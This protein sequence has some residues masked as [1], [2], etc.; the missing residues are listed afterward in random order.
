MRR[1]CLLLAALLPVVWA[2]APAQTDAAI[3]Q[4]MIA[5]S[6]AAYPGNCPCPYNSMRN[7]RA[8]GGR[9]AYNRPGGRAPLCYAQDISA[10][11]LRSY[12]Q[13]HGL[14]AP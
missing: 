7:G 4:R 10:D 8:C 6:I 13:Q 9:S 12:R 1:Y 2:K 3:A 5:E 14:S 11:M